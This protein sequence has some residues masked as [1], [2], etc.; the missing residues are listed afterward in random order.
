MT[1]KQG[2][3]YHAL[4]TIVNDIKTMFLI[5][6]HSV[7]N[8]ENFLVFASSPVLVG[9]GHTKFGRSR[10]NPTGGNNH[11]SRVPKCNPNFLAAKGEREGGIKHQLPHPCPVKWHRESA[12]QQAFSSF[13]PL[14]LLKGV[15]RVPIMYFFCFAKDRV[16]RLWKLYLWLV[17]LPIHP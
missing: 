4:M 6:C 10:I 14:F 7:I 3:I 5:V 8:I 17:R 9:L 13:S 2:I 15:S 1:V 12:P 16:W 11:F